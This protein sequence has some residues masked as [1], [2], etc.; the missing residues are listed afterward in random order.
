M[1]RDVWSSQN[2]CES[3]EIRHP[4]VKAGSEAGDE[5]LDPFHHARW[6]H[7]HLR[8]LEA[9]AGPALVVDLGDD[10]DEEGDYLQGGGEHGK[11]GGL[12]RQEGSYEPG[13]RH[14]WFQ[15]RTPT[16]REWRGE[17]PPQ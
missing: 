8:P 14:P 1:R 2:H 11:G 5:N 13:E 17:C 9:V 4:S 3:R 12:V 6:A 7:I 15:V 16:L 10:K